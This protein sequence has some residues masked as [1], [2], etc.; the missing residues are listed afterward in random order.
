[1]HE[2]PHMV[3][4]RGPG[5]RASAPVQRGRSPSTPPMPLAPLDES[6]R[7]VRAFSRLRARLAVVVGIVALLAAAILWLG[8]AALT[9]D[10]VGTRFGHSVRSGNT[11]ATLI[12]RLE[13]AMPRLHRDPSK[14]RYTVG[15][16]LH[17]ADG[18]SPPRYIELG[19]GLTASATQHSTLVG[20]DARRIWFRA[21]EPGALDLGTGRVLGA[22]EYARVEALA[23]VRSGRL[24]DLAIG[25]RALL[26][27]VAAG[28]MLSPGRFIALLTETEVS[29]S[30]KPGSTAKPIV[31]A[32]RSSEPVLLWRSDV[33]E[34]GVRLRLKEL[35]ARPDAPLFHAGFLRASRDGPLLVLSEPTGVL[36][37][38]E[39]DRYRSG[40]VLLSRLDDGGGEL[41][42]RDLGI[43]RLEEILPDALRPAFIGTRPARQG[44]VPE[45]ILV[46]VD[47]ASGALSTHS[48]LRVK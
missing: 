22:A 7:F 46:I 44:E 1:M 25:D 10:S 45:P 40:T 27:H 41:W 15:M 36:R 34:D 26:L 37:I 5:A 35:V 13:S 30:W 9:L 20:A 4:G 47:V 42:R 16:L 43:A 29:R 38:H 32:E 19:R 24:S 48:L 28:G 33:E 17:A 8:R 3:V 21:P 2:P 12:Q 6:A 23:P 14:D 11:I 31:P 18:S 39:S